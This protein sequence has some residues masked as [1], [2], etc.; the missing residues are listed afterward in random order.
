MGMKRSCRLRYHRL[1]S[2]FSSFFLKDF[3][4]LSLSLSLFSP[5]NPGQQKERERISSPSV[6]HSEQLW[7]DRCWRMQWGKSRAT[8]C[9][10]LLHLYTP[11]YLLIKLSAGSSTGC[12]PTTAHR[13][14]VRFDWGHDTDVRSIPSTDIGYHFQSLHSLMLHNMSSFS[15][16]TNITCISCRDACQVMIIIS[17]CSY[18]HSLFHFSLFHCFV[19]AF[20]PSYLVL[21][22]LHSRGSYFLA[23]VKGRA[24]FMQL[25]SFFYPLF[26]S[27]L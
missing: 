6:S 26:C 19:S 18:P 12:M 2:L 1:S 5:E 21:C 4:S 17:I 11:C 13:R 10:C 25:N 8:K 24:G 3:L 23:S 16:V 20:S 14:K 15:P 7:S 22:S 27:L 9:W